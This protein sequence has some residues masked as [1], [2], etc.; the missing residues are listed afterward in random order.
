MR[1]TR[2]SKSVR[3]CEREPDSF[4]Q[5]PSLVQLVS[6]YTRETRR[7]FLLLLLL[8]LLLIM[9]LLLMFFVLLVVLLHVVAYAV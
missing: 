4:T 3:V 1:R 2:E 6:P 7:L 5:C 9:L 8:L